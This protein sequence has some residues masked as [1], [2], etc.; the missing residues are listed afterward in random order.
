M[1]KFNHTNSILTIN[2]AGAPA[3]KQ[4]NYDAFVKQLLCMMVNEPKYYGDNTNSFIEFVNEMID[5]DPKFVAQSAVFARTVG[6]MRSVSHLVC[7]IL[8]NRVKGQPYIR[9]AIR[10]CIVRGD[11]VTEMLAAYIYLFG[12]PIPNSL[13]RG[14]RD[15]MEY[16]S[17]YTLAKYRGYGKEVSMADA[18]K[19]CH[20]NF[21]NPE[22][23]EAANLL[24]RTELKRPISWETDLAK[25]SNN[26][27]TWERLIQE[28]KVPYM[29]MLRNLRNIQDAGVDEAT[30]NLVKDKLTNIDAIKKSKQFPYR[31][32]SALSCL[33]DALY[34]DIVIAALNKSVENFPKLKGKTAIFVDVSGSMM[35]KDA[36][37]IAALYA[38]V[39]HATCKDE[40]YIIQYSYDA[41]KVVMSKYDSVY[42]NSQTFKFE[43]GG[44]NMASAFWYLIDTSIDVNRIINLTDNEANSQVRPMQFIL[45]KYRAKV[46]HDVWCH[47]WD[48]AG[49]DKTTQVIGK[50][51][52][53]LS[54]FSDKMFQYI[55]L[56]ESGVTSIIEDIKK[57]NL[58]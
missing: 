22:S 9:K 11:D 10:H 57:I 53:Y 48:L 42:T 35:W 7:A 14:L 56:T 43:W 46:G 47:M 52:N 20:P 54:G 32:Q 37:K 17:P 18:V 44:T 25:Y 13:R 5:T 45:D 41:Q 24:V 58:M 19:I 28:D 33:D 39:I 15:A 12:K 26:C 38:A 1:S 31:Y 29:A 27:D 30:F 40:V 6:N 23:Q 49:N 4:D 36:A 21:I 3:Y 50:H 55:T 34:R 8:S 2:A 16:F 51:T